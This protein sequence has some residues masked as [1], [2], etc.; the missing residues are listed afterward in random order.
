MLR[1]YV[2]KIIF[3]TFCWSYD[4]TDLEIDVDETQ[5]LNEMYEVDGM[6]ELDE[7]DALNGKYTVDRSEE[8]KVIIFLTTLKEGEFFK[9]AKT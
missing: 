6:E 5:E 8:P 7:L 2:I 1:L 4:G 9:N 3:F